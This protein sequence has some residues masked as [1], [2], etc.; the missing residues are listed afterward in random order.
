M[1]VST[2]ELL[3]IIES[4][5]LGPSPPTPAQRVELLHAIRSSLP[6]FQ[7]LLSYPVRLLTRLVAEKMLRR[8]KMMGVSFWV[9]FGFAVSLA[10]LIGG[11]WRSLLYFLRVWLVVGGVIPVLLLRKWRK[12]EMMRISFWLVCFWKEFYYLRVWW[13]CNECI[14]ILVA[15]KMRERELLWML[16]NMAVSLANLIG[17]DGRHF[18]YYLWA[19]C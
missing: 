9:L 14:F 19:S 3:S 7:S 1:V 12:R 2:K 8:E 6:A 5:L 13:C 10:D 15:E 11:D 18:L 16:N 4:A 17:D